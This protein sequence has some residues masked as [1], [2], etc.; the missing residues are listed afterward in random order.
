MVDVFMSWKRR[1]INQSPFA[2]VR[3]SQLKEAQ[4]AIQNLYGTEIRGC[5][6]SMTMA[7]FKRTED[8]NIDYEERKVAPQNKCNDG[9]NQNMKWK[10][11]Y[12]KDVVLHK[13]G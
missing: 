10:R 8:K 9:G 3:F 5:K 2:F 11:R 7:E 6:I 1:K 12:F 4:K 13:V